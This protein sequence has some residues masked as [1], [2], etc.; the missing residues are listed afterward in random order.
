MTAARRDAQDRPASRQARQALASPRTIRATARARDLDQDNRRL[1]ESQWPPDFAES[2]FLGRAARRLGDDAAWTALR[3]G[4]LGAQ[5]YCVGRTDYDPV[6]IAPLV[7]L[8]ADRVDAL[9]GFQIE[10]RETDQRRSVRIRRG[11][12]VPH[13]LF[14]TKAS[15]ERLEKTAGASTAGA[16]VRARKHLVDILRAEPNIAKAEARERLAQYALSGQ[17][18]EDRVWP[19]ARKEAGLPLQARAGRKPRKTVG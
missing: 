6:G 12:P 5:V 4:E 3:S 7:F 1:D 14:V 8:S 11:I 16:E 18:F 17:G 2:I 13:W 19:N 10:I 9:S 15:L